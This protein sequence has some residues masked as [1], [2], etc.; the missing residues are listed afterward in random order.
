MPHMRRRHW[1]LIW[2][3]KQKTQKSGQPSLHL[4]L[5]YCYWQWMLLHRQKT[6]F[7]KP[8]AKSSQIIKNKLR[9]LKHIVHE[10][11]WGKSVS[12][13]VLQS[14]DGTLVT[15]QPIKPIHSAHTNMFWHKQSYFKAYLQTH[16]H[17][18]THGVGQLY[19]HVCN[20]QFPPFWPR[21]HMIHRC[22][23]ESVRGQR[24]C[25]ATIFLHFR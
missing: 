23:L 7:Q 25:T 17:K 3:F 21:G 1:T 4:S 10:L 16:I 2:F 13:E 24:G 19:F 22:L 6:K 12:R 9:N 14:C 5:L 11:W 18:Q 8:K 20:M 15:C